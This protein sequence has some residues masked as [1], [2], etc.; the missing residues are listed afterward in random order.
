MSKLCSLIAILALTGCKGPDIFKVSAE[1]QNLNVYRFFKLENNIVPRYGFAVSD[2]SYTFPTK[3]WVEEFA[4]DFYLNTFLPKWTKDS[5]DCDDHSKIVA[6]QARLYHYFHGGK[7][8]QTGIAFGEFYY[9]RDNGTPH[10][11]NFFITCQSN[12][13]SLQ[14]FEPQTLKIVTLSD[15]EKTNCLNWL[16]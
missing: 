10:A 4:H 8:S 6:G 7:E 14:F 2:D 16:L 13:F 1:D 5:F 11:I 3:E 12:K 9:R 15:K